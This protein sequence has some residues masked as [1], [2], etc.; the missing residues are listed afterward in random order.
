MNAAHRI[1]LYMS[2]GA[3]CFALC[4]AQAAMQAQENA[5]SQPATAASKPSKAAMPTL[6]QCRRAQQTWASVL[7]DT[8]M[9]MTMIERRAWAR[10]LFD[11]ACRKDV[12]DVARYVLLVA[13]ADQAGAGGDVDLLREAAA[14]LEQQYEEHDRLAFLVKRVGLAGPACA[15]PERFEKALAAAF[16]VVDQAVA[17]ER[18]EL[19]NEL[20]S[21]VASW[22][23]QR[24]AKGLAVHVE[25]RQKAIAALI[26]REATLQKARA[27]LKDNPADPGAN[28]I[29]GMH[30]A[31]Y[32]Q[33]WPGALKHF[34]ACGNE[35]LARLSLLEA[36]QGPSADEMLALA[37]GWRDE[38]KRENSEPV[39]IA[40]QQR[41]AEW[42]GKAVV[43]LKDGDKADAQKQLGE[44]MMA[45]ASHKIG[46]LS[47]WTAHGGSWCVTS[48]G[49]FK[50]QGPSSLSF[51]HKFPSDYYL[52][53]RVNVLEGMRPRFHLS[54]GMYIGNEG[55]RRY[56]QPHQ[57]V[58]FRGA[59]V[60]Y[61]NGQ[62]MLMGV[63]FIG[64]TFRWYVDGR[65]V[66]QGERKDAPPLIT[67]TLSPGDDWSKGVATFWDFKLLPKKPA[68]EAKPEGSSSTDRD[69]NL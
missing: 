45:V 13:S 6:E 15:W 57:A 69:E 56:I 52:E 25:A 27:A 5:S 31:C 36:K 53:F 26:D 22:A 34:A 50:G 19:A 12:D 49:K 62:S 24:N 42:F 41:A 16:D 3:V 21:A 48:D 43:G 35:N 8:G 40:Y 33:D 59:G 47:E 28:L 17:A 65:L 61:E 66:G 60:F 4:M 9:D 55:P 30:L 18:Y 44:L 11:L 39:K 7:D 68:Q 58:S 67:L 10:K 20:L 37:E 29:V 23:V 38:A 14:K 46:S 63:E 1:R 64:K 2:I 32:Q 51:K 54:P